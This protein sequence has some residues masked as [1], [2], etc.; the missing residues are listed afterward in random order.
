[1]PIWGKKKKKREA[2]GPCGAHEAEMNLQPRSLNRKRETRETPSGRRGS[3]HRGV[4][5]V[6]SFAVRFKTSDI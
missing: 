3:L 2:L 5:W 1:M 6:T 4:G